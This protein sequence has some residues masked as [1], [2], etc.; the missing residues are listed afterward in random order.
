[1]PT[2]FLTLEQLKTE[3]RRQCD[4]LEGGQSTFARRGGISRVYVTAVLSGKQLPG[5]K[6]LGA[7]GYEKVVLYRRKER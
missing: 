4:A 3:L 7:M 2:P 1:M 6:L 5:P